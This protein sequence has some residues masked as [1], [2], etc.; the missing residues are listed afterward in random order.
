M[1]MPSNEFSFMS[2]F[3]N[4]LNWIK[5]LEKKIVRHIFELRKSKSQIIYLLLSFS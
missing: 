5:I 1:S 2:D 3:R 4:P